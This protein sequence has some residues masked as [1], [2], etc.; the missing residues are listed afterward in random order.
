MQISHYQDLQASIIGEQIE[1]ELNKNK[2]SYKSRGR[3]AM[4]YLFANCE[5]T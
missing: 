4:L 3:G 1:C 2:C 5:M